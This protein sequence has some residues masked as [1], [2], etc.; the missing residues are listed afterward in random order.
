MGASAVVIADRATAGLDIVLEALD[1]GS[2][3]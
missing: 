1:F 2:G 3:L